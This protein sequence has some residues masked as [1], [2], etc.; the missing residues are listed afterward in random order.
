MVDIKGPLL[1]ERLPV[2]FPGV[3]EMSMLEVAKY[4][5]Y[6]RSI[7]LSSEKDRFFNLSEVGHSQ[8]RFGASEKQSGSALSSSC[9]RGGVSAW[10]SGQGGMR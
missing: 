8:L 9:K 3:F 7:D 2:G 10:K 6:S 5:F 4:L 1:T